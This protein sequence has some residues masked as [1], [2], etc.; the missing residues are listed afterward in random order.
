VNK[1]Y[2]ASQVVSLLVFV[3]LFT[4]YLV[5]LL[6]AVA[7]VLNDRMISEECIGSY[8]EGSDDG[9]NCGVS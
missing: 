7:I 2:K 4:V 9:L 3:Y 1:K 8:R 5:L 6:L